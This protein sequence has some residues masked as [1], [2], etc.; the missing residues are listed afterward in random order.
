MGSRRRRLSMLLPSLPLFFSWEYRAAAP[1]A[2]APATTGAVGNLSPL[3]F[4]LSFLLL[5]QPQPQPDLPESDDS[6]LP[7]YGLLSPPKARAELV[8]DTDR[9][10]E[11][12]QSS[13]VVPG[14]EERV[15]CRRGREARISP[16]RRRLGRP[17]SSED[18]ASAVAAALRPRSSAS[19]SRSLSLFFFPFLFLLPVGFFENA[20]PKAKSLSRDEDDEL[21]KEKMLLRRRSLGFCCFCRLSED[22]VKNDFTPDEDGPDGCAISM[23]DDDEDVEYGSLVRTLDGEPRFF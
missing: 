10:S 21:L 17:A 4:F 16:G 6:S 5:P 22:E 19:T 7:A 2:A 13:S 12:S 8:L 14:P 1:T 20:L 11:S 18:A 23:Y 15:S 9:P 3:F